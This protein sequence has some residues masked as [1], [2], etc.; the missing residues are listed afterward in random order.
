M[1]VAKDIDYIFHLAASVG[2]IH[3]IKR[4]N[5][6]G[7]TPSILMNTNMSSKKKMLFRQIRQLHTG[8]RK[9]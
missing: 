7:S 2:G 6:E 4:E 8:G 1:L 3:Y 9:C 5:V